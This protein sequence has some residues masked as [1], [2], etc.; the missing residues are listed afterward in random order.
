[1]NRGKNNKQSKK[2]NTK[3]R[4]VDLFPA[5]KNT[6]DGDRYGYINKDGE[7]II[8]FKFT[9]AYDFNEFGL[10]II[11]ENNKFGI[12]DIKGNYNVNPQFDNINPYI[13]RLI[14]PSYYL[15]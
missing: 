15:N 7:V 12:I 2:K 8:P 11:K 4:E 10:A 1:M 5:L 14:F 6:I 3:K 9:R 13:L